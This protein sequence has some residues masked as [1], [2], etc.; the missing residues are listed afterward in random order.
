MLPRTRRQDSR[1][2]SPVFGRSGFREPG[3]WVHELTVPQI[4]SLRERE[5]D[6]HQ[7]AETT[8][9]GV[10]LKVAG[11]DAAEGLTG[12]AGDGLRA[13]DAEAVDEEGVEH[14]HDS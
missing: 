3:S 12:V 9:E 14:A 8:E 10:A 1:R 13:A 2:R 5:E 4:R 7:Y 11:L 6:H